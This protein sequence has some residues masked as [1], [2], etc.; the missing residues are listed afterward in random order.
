LGAAFHSRRGDQ[1]TGACSSPC[2]AS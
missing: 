2:A 1:V